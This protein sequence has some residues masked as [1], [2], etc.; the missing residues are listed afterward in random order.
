MLEDKAK[1]K[2][3]WMFAQGSTGAGLRAQQARAAQGAQSLLSLP[4]KNEKDESSQAP[5][6]TR[7]Y[8]SLFSGLISSSYSP[9]LLHGPSVLF[10]LFL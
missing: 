6:K 1:G 9:V 4:E 10:H 8:A 2:P 3:G 7:T 5:Y